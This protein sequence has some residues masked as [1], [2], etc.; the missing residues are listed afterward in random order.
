MGPKAQIEFD[1]T[2]NVAAPIIRHGD[3]A[4]SQESMVGRP[5]HIQFFVF[6]TSAT[7][8]DDDQPR[9]A[10]LFLFLAMTWIAVRAGEVFYTKPRY[11]H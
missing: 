4:R 2:N 3:N 10:P 9:Y 5:H 1:H 8:V 6:H 7:K 11:R